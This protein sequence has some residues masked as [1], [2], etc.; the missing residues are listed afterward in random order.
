MEGNS[1]LGLIAYGLFLSLIISLPILVIIIVVRIIRRMDSPH[2]KEMRRLLEH[3]A[4]LLEENNRL[5]NQQNS[6]KR[7]DENRETTPPAGQAG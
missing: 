3:I 4:D 2:Q 6:G 1:I 5:L 7:P